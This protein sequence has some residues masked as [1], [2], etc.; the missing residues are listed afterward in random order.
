MPVTITPNDVVPAACEALHPAGTTAPKKQEKP[1]APS[2]ADSKSAGTA[3]TSGPRDE[4]DAKDLHCLSE[5][6]E[7]PRRCKNPEAAEPS[8]AKSTTPDAV[9]GLLSL[10]AEASIDALIEGE[11]KFRIGTGLRAEAGAKAELRDKPA[12]T[13][14]GSKAEPESSETVTAESV[15]TTSTPMPKTGS[16]VCE[17]VP[18][19]RADPPSGANPV[20]LLVLGRA[21]RDHKERDG[22]ARADDLAARFELE[23]MKTTHGHKEKAEAAGR[24]GTRTAM[25]WFCAAIALTIALRCFWLA[26]YALEGADSLFAILVG[27]VC[28]ILPGCGIIGNHIDL[29]AARAQ[30]KGTRRQQKLDAQRRKISGVPTPSWDY[31]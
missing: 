26:Y 28:L 6:A 19:M 12:N 1:E 7:M 20:S 23:L 3:P 21:S 15:T 11:L 5:L 13:G 8:T 29:T 31:Y 22:A 4:G 18:A 2:L 17:A 9:S 16:G 10:M 24:E 27:Y 30:R 14:T 25:I